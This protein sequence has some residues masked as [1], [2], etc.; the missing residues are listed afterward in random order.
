LPIKMTLFTDPAM[1]FSYRR[2]AR[3]P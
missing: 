1:T 2:A 3:P